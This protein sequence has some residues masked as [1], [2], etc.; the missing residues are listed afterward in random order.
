MNKT[1]ENVLDYWNRTDVPLVQPQDAEALRVTIRQA[2]LAVAEDFIDFFLTTGGMERDATDHD[3]WSC[4]DIAKIVEENRSYPR[5]GVL[6]ADWCINA[7][8]HL[9]RP[10][11]PTVSSVW[12]DMFSGDEPFKVADSFTEFFERYLAR[13]SET[14]VLFGDDPMRNKVA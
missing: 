4:W 2:G 13:D 11:S 3:M 10:E 7:H 5:P 14:F 12:V 1:F 8:L 9:V 6:F